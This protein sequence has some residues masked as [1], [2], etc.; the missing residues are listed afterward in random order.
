M[1][2]EDSGKAA[3]AASG[4]WTRYWRAGALHSCGCAWRGNYEGVVAAF[5]NRCFDTLADGAVLVD[6][7]TGN[8]A[9]PLLAV[10]AARRLGRSWQVHG[11]DL[12]DIEP[13]AATGTQNAAADLARVRFHPRTSATDL[14][15]AD[16]AVDLLSGQYAFEYLPRGA[17]VAEAARVLGGRGR[18][19][20]VV[21]ARDSE[22]LATTAEQL[23]LCALLFDRSGFFEALRELAARLAAASDP[24]ARAALA[25]DPAAVAARD[26]LNAAAAQLSERI[27]SA[28]TPDLPQLALGRASEALRQAAGWG[29]ARTLAY[30][31]AARADLEDE[32]QRLV[33]LDAAALDAQGIANLAAQLGAAGIGH[34]QVQPLVHE[35]GARLGWTL[36]AGG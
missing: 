18:I 12:A 35:N 22:L 26:R 29:V 14:P 4:K 2:P 8:G 5:W 20:L 6:V 21:H 9:I 17:A 11:V 24:G 23:A 32:R 34:A 19:A 13:A 10:A 27:A 25:R 28:R 1:D 3:A 30:V 33:D 31:D 16:G 15:F 7:G 36:L